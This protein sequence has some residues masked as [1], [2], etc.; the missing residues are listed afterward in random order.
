[1]PGKGERDIEAAE[2]AAAIRRAGLVIPEAEL[3]E[4]RKGAALLPE[5]LARLRDPARPPGETFLSL[6]CPEDP[7][8]DDDG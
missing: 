8:P 1:M 7:R 6:F 3:A 2:F 4:L 5:L